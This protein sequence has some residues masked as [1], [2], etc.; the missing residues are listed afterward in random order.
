MKDIK[1]LT[2][3]QMEQ[4]AG[5]MDTDLGLTEEQIIDLKTRLA[6]LI[7]RRNLGL[8]IRSPN[9]HILD[10]Y[11]PYPRGLGDNNYQRLQ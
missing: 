6:D 8:P 5:G 2:I 11:R 10:E 4:I 1:D 9:Q 7:E 3:E